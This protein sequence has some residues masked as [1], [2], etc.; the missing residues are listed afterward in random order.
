MGDFLIGLTGKNF[1]LYL[2]YA[3]FVAFSLILI[4]KVFPAKKNLEIVIVLLVMGLI[5]FFLISRTPFLAKLS[6][7][8]FFLLGILVSLE[9]KKSKSFL[10]F[11]LLFAAALLVEV[12]NNLSLGSRFYYLDVWL[13]S[14][15]GLSG[16]LAGLLII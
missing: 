7:L 1:L 10:P 5:F 6:I 9:N 13:N 4:I 2:I 3:L 15:T 11:I 8:E 14:L 16:F 12:A